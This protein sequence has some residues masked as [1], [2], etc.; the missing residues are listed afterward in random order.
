MVGEAID[1]N[2]TRV[3]LD[4]VNIILNLK[5]SPSETFTRE[6]LTKLALSQHHPEATCLISKRDGE[7]GVDP[8]VFR[9]RGPRKTPNELRDYI[10]KTLKDKVATQLSLDRAGVVVVRF[11]GIHDPQVARHEGSTWK[12]VQPSELVRRGSPLRRSCRG[13]CSEH[14]ALD[15]WHCFQK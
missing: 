1:A 9:C 15:S 4:R 6:E 5:P 14:S 12:V 11:S 7:L 10:Y 8:V 3:Q 2:Q 13:G